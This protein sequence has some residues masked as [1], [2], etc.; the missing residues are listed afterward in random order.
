MHCDLLN[1]ILEKMYADP[2]IT[3]SIFDIFEKFPDYR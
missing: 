2:H 3:S 1:N